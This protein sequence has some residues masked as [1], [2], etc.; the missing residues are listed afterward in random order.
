VPENAIFFSVDVVNLYGSIPLDGAIEAVKETLENHFEDI[1]ACGLNVDEICSLLKHCL[2]SNIFRFGEEFYL[3]KQGV[4]MGN[5]VAPIVAILFMHRF[6]SLA[7]Q[8]ASQ[9]SLLD[10]I[11]R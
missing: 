5:P 3:Q 9:T 7:L 8:H 11:Y 6:E 1:D 4:A 10:K 2:M